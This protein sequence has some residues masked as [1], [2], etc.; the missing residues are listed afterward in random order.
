MMA[1]AA[2][3]AII[4]AMTGLDWGIAAFVALVAAAGFARG[5]LV[6]ALSLAGFAAGAFVGTRLAPRLL[7]VGAASPG[8]PLLGLAF[9]VLGGALLAG[10][11]AGLGQRLRARIASRGAGALDGVLG[12]ALSAAVA[13]GIAWLAGAAARQSAPAEGLRE[14]VQRSL[15]LRR[16]NA[17]LPPTGPI[18]ERLARFDPFPRLRGP[19]PDVAA[20]S[21][22]IARDPDVR[23][24]RASVVRVVGTTCGLGVSGSGWVAAPGVVV[25]NAHVVAGQDDTQVQPGGDGA[26]LDAVA[27]AVD[28]RNDVAVLRVAGL[29]APALPLAD[30]VAS[31]RPAAVLGFP[32][33]GPYAVR[34][35]PWRGR[36]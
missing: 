2:A 3:R 16:L 18:L 29:S 1:A 5:F 23:A 19:Q 15:I 31:G 4:T 20:P 17:A 7:E 6:G 22:R 25:T 34:A 21:P 35:A 26:L 33:N 30:G 36:S 13:L 12:A 10:G 24:A 14:E 32:R 11:L 9:G 28:R 27:V 8:A